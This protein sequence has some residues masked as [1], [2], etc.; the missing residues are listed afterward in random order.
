M[1]TKQLTCPSDEA[2]IESYKKLKLKNIKFILL[3]RGLTSVNTI[4]G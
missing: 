1:F 2:I 3:K 4:L